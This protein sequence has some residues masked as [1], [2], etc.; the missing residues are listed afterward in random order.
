MQVSTRGLA[1]H[2]RGARV[3]LGA[4]HAKHKDAT[5][6]RERERARELE[7]ARERERE[8]ER[9]KPQCVGAVHPPVGKRELGLDRREPG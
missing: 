5:G 1:T 8:R 4:L 9:D 2:G 6:G 7:S 3:A